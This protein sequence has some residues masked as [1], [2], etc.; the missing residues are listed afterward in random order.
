VFSCAEL[1][2]VCAVTQQNVDE[3][4]GYANPTYFFSERHH[5]DLAGSL[6]LTKNTK[7]FQ[8]TPKIT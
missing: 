8:K 2:E 7:V 1:V 5:K 4:L 3:S 6:N